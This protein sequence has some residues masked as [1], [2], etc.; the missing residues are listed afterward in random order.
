MV[1]QWAA[2]GR[3]EWCLAKA[4]EFAAQ[5]QF[6][7]YRLLSDPGVG[8]GIFDSRM[9]AR[10]HGASGLLVGEAFTIIPSTINYKI[11]DLK[12]IDLRHQIHLRSDLINLRK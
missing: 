3:R 10:A 9:S 6:R 2:G 12:L 11:L 7:L 4:A 5:R 1:F 8:R